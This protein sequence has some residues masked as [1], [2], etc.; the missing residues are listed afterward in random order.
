MAT[1]DDEVEISEPYLKAF[2]VLGSALFV[3][4]LLSMGGDREIVPT[5]VIIA[6]GTAAV[7]GGLYYG[8]VR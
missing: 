8:L 5:A 4:Q 6:A 1:T 2:L 7:A 3:T